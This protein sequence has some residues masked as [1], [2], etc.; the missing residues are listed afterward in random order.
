MAGNSRRARTRIRA[1]FS[2]LEL[3]VVVAIIAV[4][5]TA[6][7]AGYRSSVR[8]AMLAEMIDNVGAIITAEKIQKQNTDKYADA[9]NVTAIK[10][11]LGVNVGSD[12]WD[13]NVTGA[14]ASSFTV[15]VV[16]K[17]AGFGIASPAS[18][19]VVYTDGT[20]LDLNKDSL[21]TPLY[22]P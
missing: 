18:A 4:L 16:S 3:M 6:A 14:T 7:V 19:S 15:T 11:T 22:E 9:A 13:Y 5:A 2:L 21:W 20:T 1:G 10:N 8:K 12:Q 17:K